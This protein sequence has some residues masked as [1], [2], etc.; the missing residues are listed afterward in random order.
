VERITLILKAI[1]DFVGADEIIA[2][3]DLPKILR[4][5]ITEINLP[6]GVRLTTDIKPVPVFKGFKNSFRLAI[7]HSVNRRVC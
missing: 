6:D 5:L 7:W 4:S 3:I 1:S 2:E